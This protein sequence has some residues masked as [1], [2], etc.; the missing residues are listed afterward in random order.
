MRTLV[1]VFF[2]LLVL[3]IVLDIA[4]PQSARERAADA[5]AHSI[6]SQQPPPEVCQ[7]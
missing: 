5:I 1:K 2:W 7:P 6:C 3:G 4:W